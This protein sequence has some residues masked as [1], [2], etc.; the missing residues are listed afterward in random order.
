MSKLLPVLVVFTFAA[1]SAFSILS[2]ENKKR[3]DT[4]DFTLESDFKNTDEIP[5]R[6]TCEGENISPPLTWSGLP[7]KTQSLALIIEDPDAPDPEAPRRIWVHWVLYNIPKSLRGLKEGER[8]FPP[9]SRRG[10]NDWKRN[11]YEGPCPPIGRHRYFFRLY[12]L[13]TLLSDLPEANKTALQKAMKG[14]VLAEAVLMGTYQ[15]KN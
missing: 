6:Y 8:D 4:M 11:I 3:G 13:D 14:H 7:D 15:K 1:L 9:E 5:P 2:A 10:L 12:A